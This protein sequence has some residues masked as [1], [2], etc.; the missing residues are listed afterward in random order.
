MF[1]IF[2]ILL[3]F[4]KQLIFDCT[5]EYMFKSYKFNTRKFALFV[6][7]VVLSIYSYYMTEKFI[8]ISDMI[9]NGK[10]HELITE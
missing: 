5:D 6:L 7:I 1:K 4:I 9:H 3:A 2:L 10:C 8:Y